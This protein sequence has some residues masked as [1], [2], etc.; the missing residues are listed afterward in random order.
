MD[1]ELNAEQR[2]WQSK[3]RAFA[4]EEIRPLSLAREAIADPVKTF[5]WEIIKKGSRLGF[6]TAVVPR[7]WGGHG[8]DYVTQALVMSELA[9]ADSAISKTF[10]QCWK[11]SHRIARAC[12]PDQ[13]DRFLT[14]FLEDDT[15]LIG[16]ASTEPNAGSDNRLQPE[17]DP[18]AGLK[19]RAERQGDDWLLNGDK[20][21]I[22]NGSVAKLFFISTR[23]NPEVKLREGN[24]V[25][26]LPRSTPG[27]R[28][29]KVFNKAGWRFYQNAELILENVRLPHANVVGE[30][31][32]GLK[33]RTRGSLD[34]SDFELAANAL[35]N[36]DA[37]VGSAMQYVRQDG[38]ASQQRVQLQL[39]EMHMLTE[40]L[41]AYVMRV[42]WEMDAQMRESA[43]VGLVMNFARD[44]SQRV[45]VLN[46]EIHGGGA[47]MHAH[48][49][50]LV[51]DT[52]IW[53]HLAGD[54][55]QRM[56]SVRRL[57]R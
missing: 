30:V 25:F 2:A 18:R 28:H 12:T 35:G 3:A 19:L 57:L 26:L 13:R 56:K 29:A 52:I 49:D 17:N 36:C 10:S 38:L 43:N 15:F 7:E 53:T 54:S 55:V 45:S 22:A 9:R 33:T 44:V 37:A 51:R 32:G 8:I 31:N 27:F 46:M 21:F 14:P 42:A 41:R 24:T 39:A 47:Q 4:E 48:S 20:C 5:D 40:A 1:F 50:K 34:F 23:T 6:R 11:F 16:G